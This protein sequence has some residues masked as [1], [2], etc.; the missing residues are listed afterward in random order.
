MTTELFLPCSLLNHDF[1]FCRKITVK[2]HKILS[3]K[4]D[5]CWRKRIFENFKNYSFQEKSHMCKLLIS[6]YK[7]ILTLIQ[8]STDFFV[9]AHFAR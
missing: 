7:Q 5:V 2:H 4:K 6:F 8:I 3:V 9:L 1:Q